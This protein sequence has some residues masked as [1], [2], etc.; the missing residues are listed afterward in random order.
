MTVED[1]KKEWRKDI[2]KKKKKKNIWVRR[3][4]KRLLTPF[5]FKD[6]IGYF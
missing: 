5:V 6:Q 3:V 2:K 1:K 4:Q